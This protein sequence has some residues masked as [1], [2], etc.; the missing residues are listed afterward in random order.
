MLYQIKFRLMVAALMSFFMALIMSGCIMATHFSPLKLPFY[1]AWFDAFI[2]AW[3]I[4]FPVAFLV[5]PI[6]LKIATKLLPPPTT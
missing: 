5:S 2:F 4:A 3:P 1:N 6:A